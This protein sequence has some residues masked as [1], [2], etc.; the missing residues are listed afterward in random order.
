MTGEPISLVAAI[1]AAV[2]GGIVFFGG[3][4]VFLVERRRRTR[5]LEEF[6][7]LSE[8]EKDVYRYVKRTHLL[9]AEWRSKLSEEGRTEVDEVF[10]RLMEKVRELQRL[11]SAGNDV[12]DQVA[13]LL[14]LEDALDRA[15]ERGRE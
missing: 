5:L 9:R 11:R 15:I 2:V 6:P 1:V 13:E 4:G 10:E 14:I 8:F 7:E 12:S 3:V